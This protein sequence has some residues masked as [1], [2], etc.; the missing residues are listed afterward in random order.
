MSLNDQPHATRKLPLI[1]ASVLFSI[2]TLLIFTLAAFIFVGLRDGYGESVQLWGLA[3]VL[4]LPVLPLLAFAERLT[5]PFLEPMGDIVWWVY[6]TLLHVLIGGLAWSLAGWGIGWV[7][8]GLI[9]SAAA[10]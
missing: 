9:V 8:R 10:A 6:P 3:A 4:D 2:H 1:A 5:R 7:V